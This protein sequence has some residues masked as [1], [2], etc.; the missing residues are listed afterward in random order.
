MTVGGQSNTPQFGFH[1]LP[2]LYVPARSY[3][4]VPQRFGVNGVGKGAGADAGVAANASDMSGIS[5][6]NNYTLVLDLIAERLPEAAGPGRLGQ[7]ILQTNSQN[8]DD[9]EVYIRP[10][11]GKRNGA[12]FS[13]IWHL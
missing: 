4:V 12:C 2:G 6:L 3:V 1:G 5:R 11:G 7:A 10:G 9:A 8:R 13:L